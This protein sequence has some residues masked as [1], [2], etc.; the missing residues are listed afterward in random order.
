MGSEAVISGWVAPGF[1]VVADA[2]A[3]NF[4][5]AEPESELGAALAVYLEGRCVADLWGGYTDAAHTRPWARDTLVNVWSASKGIVALAVAIL[6]DQG[7]ASYDDPVAKHWP[8]FAAN[9]KEAITLGQILSHQSGLNGW[10]A[11][12]TWD[13]LYDWR[14]AT[15]RPSVS[16]S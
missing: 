14:T 6:V 3:A 5:R 4:H 16:P 11:P 1:S 10:D 2:F 8:E 12:T 15:A 9:G 7:A 13:D